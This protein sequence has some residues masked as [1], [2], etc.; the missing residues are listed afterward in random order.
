MNG[1]IVVVCFKY[2]AS[3]ALL[4][5]IVVRPRLG[6]ALDLIVTWSV[7]VLVCRLA[8]V[9]DCFNAVVPF[10]KP[11]TDQRSAHFMTSLLALGHQGV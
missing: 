2:Q 9:D 8:G 11:V 3:E 10:G 4:A 6:V 5:C 1:A 7:L